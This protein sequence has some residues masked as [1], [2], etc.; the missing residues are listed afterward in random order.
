MSI[1]PAPNVAGGLVAAGAG[2]ES[3][4]C[5]PCG[6]NTADTATNDT[7]EGLLSSQ[8]LGP[9]ACDPCGAIGCCPRQTNQP[10]CQS[11]QCPPSPGP[12][13]QD[14]ATVTAFGPLRDLP[15]TCVQ[16]GVTR[17]AICGWVT[18]YS[19]V[20]MD[21]T[22]TVPVGRSANCL[23]PPLPPPFYDSSAASLAGHMSGPAISFTL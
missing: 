13:S 6:S 23:Y 21:V 20:E 22:Y 5:P 17:K 10:C 15:I 2:D 14:V 16:T 9:L 8:S 1:G 7:S 4:T 12:Y 18:F 3:L 11:G 19:D